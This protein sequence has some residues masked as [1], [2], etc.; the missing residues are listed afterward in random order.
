MNIN[1]IKIIGKFSSTV[2]GIITIPPGYNQLS[3]V[4]SRDTGLYLPW[5]SRIT[6]GR[7]PNVIRLIQGRYKPVSRSQTW[8]NDFII[9]SWTDQ[10]KLDKMDGNTHWINIK[11]PDTEL[12]SRWYGK[13]SRSCTMWSD[14]RVIQDC[15][16]RL[17]NQSPL[18]IYVDQMIKLHT[19]QC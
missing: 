13:I 15:T 8:D 19:L 4:C 12:L 9:W 5:V 17:F 2:I 18:S 14:K 3:H 1:N 16:T 10:D 11:F 6:W 7:R